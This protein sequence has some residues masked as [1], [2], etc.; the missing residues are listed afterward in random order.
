[1]ANQ[2]KSLPLKVVSDSFSFDTA[3]YDFDNQIALLTHYFKEKY[4][5]LKTTYVIKN[6][7]FILITIFS[8][9]SWRMSQYTLS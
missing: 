5:N 2:I 7:I 3:E 1:M 9:S 4:W 6:N 8:V